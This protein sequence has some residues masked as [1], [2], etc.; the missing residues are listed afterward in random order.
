MDYKASLDTT[1][2]VITGAI[3][4][5]FF[6]FA[7]SAVRAHLNGHTT[8]MHYTVSALL[9]FLLISVC[10][11]YSTRSYSVRNGKLIIH[12]I[13]GDKSIDL[14]EIASARLMDGSEGGIRTF[15]V[16]G[17]F[18][19]FGWFRLDAMGSVELHATR[20]DRRVLIEL[21]NGKR[22]VISPDDTGI[23]RQLQA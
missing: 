15:G 16:G 1:A 10:Y 4:L 11:V 20:G 3:F 6:Y 9:F 21:K 18:G 8:V 7:T 23:I 12:R 13:A 5:L 19:Y 14:R 22:F 2:T 17:L